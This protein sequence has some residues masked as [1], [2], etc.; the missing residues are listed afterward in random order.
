VSFHKT[1]LLVN[2]SDFS[3]PR[4]ASSIGTQRVPPDFSDVVG[5]ADDGQ[6]AEHKNDGKCG[7]AFEG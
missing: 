1:P 2:E 5:K 3:L 4:L 7:E 6:G